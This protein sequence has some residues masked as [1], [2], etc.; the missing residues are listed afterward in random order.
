[1]AV[2]LPAWLLLANPQSSSTAT[3]EQLAKM[4]GLA[5]KQELSHDICAG[6]PGDR[7]YALRSHIDMCEG[8]PSVIDKWM[9]GAGTIYKQH[10]P[11]TDKNIDVLTRRDEPV[12]LLTRDPRASTHGLCE[13]MLSEGKL[14]KDDRVAWEKPYRPYPTLTQSEAAMRDWNEG[15]E[16]VARERGDQFL[17]ITFEAM[18]TDREGVLQKALRHWGI[19]QVNP[20][21]DV[22]ARYVNAS[23]SRC[24]AWDSAAV[25]LASDGHT[26]GK[27]L[28][29]LAL[30][31][32]ARLPEE[33][34]GPMV[35]PDQHSVSLAAEAGA[36][37]LIFVQGLPRSG[38]TLVTDF[39][40]R[41]A[42]VDLMFNSHRAHPWD[43]ATDEFEPVGAKEYGGSSGCLNPMCGEGGYA[44][45]ATH[46]AARWNCKAYVTQAQMQG[47]NGTFVVKHPAMLLGGSMLAESC[48]SIGVS[49]SF[50]RVTRSA[51][52]WEGHRYGCTGKCR[53]KI[54]SNTEHCLAIAD[55]HKA[56]STMTVK[57]E[58]FDQLSMWRAL[59][60]HLDIEQVLPRSPPCTLLRTT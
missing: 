29:P 19:K 11:P 36:L 26:A 32:P 41:H 60:E 17:V 43:K 28:L 46:D 30:A 15:W 27:A 2:T 12:V 20:F 37:R 22:H 23:H 31:V 47:A 52:Q 50:V 21:V 40:S 57:F 13:R 38:T 9:V 45:R 53:D 56:P 33:Q 1:M 18:E 49:T 25:L 39:I 42:E 51:A 35:Q 54:I 4:A 48:A 34:R 10:L 8:V 6:A 16:K 58:D 5:S 44:G 14:T 24:D 55:E 7:F 3:M 59:E